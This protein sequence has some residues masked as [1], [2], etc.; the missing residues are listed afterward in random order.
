[1]PASRITIPLRSLVA[2]LAVP[3]LLAAPVAWAAKAKSRSLTATG[4]LV[5]TAKPDRFKAVQE[6]TVRGTPF[7]TAKMVLRSTLKQA[8]VSSTFTVTTK[9]GRVSGTATARLKLDGDTATYTGTAKI[10]SGTGRYRNARATNITF[11][12]VGP[13]S[14]KNTRVTLSGRVSY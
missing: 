6:G 8:T 3:A 1:M 5:Q 9:A 4:Q 12:G 2:A 7:G 14:A 10:T 13:V 11:R